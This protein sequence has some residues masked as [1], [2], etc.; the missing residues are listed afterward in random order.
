MNRPTRK[1]TKAEQKVLDLLLEGYTQQEIADALGIQL[2]TV[3]KHVSKLLEKYRYK[4][5]IQ[6][7]VSYYKNLLNKGK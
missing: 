3:K 7:V 2:V 4:S 6:L 1:P 5:T